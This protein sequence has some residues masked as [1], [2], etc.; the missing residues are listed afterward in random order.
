MRK[1][2]ESF[3]LKKLTRDGICDVILSQPERRR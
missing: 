1:F 2:P 3:Q